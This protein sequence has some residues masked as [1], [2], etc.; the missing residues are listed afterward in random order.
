[1]LPGPEPARTEELAPAFRLLFGHL[2][3]TERDKRVGNVLLLVQHGE[4]NPEGVFVLRGENGIHGTLVC[5]PQV[6]ATALIWPPRCVEDEHTH[7]NE[8][9]LVRRATDWLRGQGVKLAQTLLAVEENDLGASLQRNGFD[10]ITHL[11]FFRH[12]LTLPAA[13]LHHGE[14]LEYQ[15]YVE[16]DASLFHRTLERTYID[17]QDCPELNGVRGVMEVILGHQS[18]G[19]FDP[20]RWFLAFAA[21]QPVGVLLLTE[22]PESGDWDL[23]YTGIV[24][25]ARRQGFGTALV[26][27]ALI[28]AQLADAMYLSLAVDGRNHPALGLYRKLRFEP[29]DRREV[30]LGRVAAIKRGE[31]ARRKPAGATQHRRADA[32]PLVNMT[33]CRRR[34]L[35][36]GCRVG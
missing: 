24:P 2:E 14:R 7:E 4:L 34:P 32:A 28:E 8:D 16:C 23:S 10:H 26:V 13:G 12:D 36:F 9:R 25:E 33:K 30:Y 6:G 27:K 18:Q 1:M 11:N 17:T 3:P 5:V 15:T 19:R 29:Y 21:G 35:A 31:R 22:V 20:D